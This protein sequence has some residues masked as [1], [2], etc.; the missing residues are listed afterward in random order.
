MDKEEKKGSKRSFDLNKNSKRSFDL[1]KKSTRKFDLSKESELVE[2]VKTT[3]PQ[4]GTTPIQQ[5][6]MSRVKGKL[7]WLIMAIIIIFIIVVVAKMCKGSNNGLPV[8]ATDTTNVKQHSNTTGSDSVKH[9][10]IAATDDESSSVGQST[11]VTSGSEGAMKSTAPVSTNTDADITAAAN[12]VLDGEFGNGVERKQKL[13]D[14][15]QTIQNK[16]NDMYRKGLA[17]RR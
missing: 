16:V 10:S 1:D 11:K 9:D 3:T 5:A 14:N 6:P 7:L 15:Y 8:P 13:G 17:P 4:P 2:E 12:R